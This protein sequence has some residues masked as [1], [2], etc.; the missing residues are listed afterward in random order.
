MIE[1][2]GNQKNN[3]RALFKGVEHHAVLAAVFAGE[4][5]AQI[6]VDNEVQPCAGMIAYNGKFIFGGAPNQA[7]FNAELRAQFMEKIIPA[8]DGDAFMIRADAPEWL[9]ALRKV[10]GE[11]GAYGGSRLYFETDPRPAENISLPKGFALRPATRDLLESNL[12]GLDSLRAE[13]CSER[14]SVED[15]LGKSFGLCP[16]YENEIVGWC[17]SEYNINDRCEIGIAVFE[18]HQRQGVATALTRAFLAEAYA[19]G[20]RRVGWDCWESN[21]ASA[22]TARKAGF[23]FVQSEQAMVIVLGGC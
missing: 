7:E 1:I 12:G 4:V 21:A 2:T 3:V 20:Y 17:L 11:H 14:V 16:I 22:A 18:P 13:M 19:R 9:P 23:E 8:Y 15:F 6:Y 10:F 5:D